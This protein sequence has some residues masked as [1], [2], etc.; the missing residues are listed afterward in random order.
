MTWSGQEG[1]EGQDEAEEGAGPTIHS[2]SSLGRIL[3]LLPR[4]TETV[5]RF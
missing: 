1:R 3:D 2:L 5:E 4:A